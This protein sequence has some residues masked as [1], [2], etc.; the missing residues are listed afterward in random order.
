LESSVAEGR[1]SGV[2]QGDFSIDFIG[3]GTRRA[4]TTWLYHCLREHPEICMS[5]VKETFVFHD[6]L[7][8]GKGRDSSA[9]EKYF[10]HC[11][12]GTIK[13]EFTPHYLFDPATP[14]LIR[15]S[16]PDA[17]LV[18][19]FRNPVDRLESLYYFWKFRGRHDFETFEEFLEKEEFDA[20]N[21]TRYFSHL[22]RWLELFPRENILVLVY[23]D[24]ARDPA[25]F[26]R[27]VYS[28]LG[29]DPAFVPESVGKSINM[30]KDSKGQ[31]LSRLSYKVIRN[32]ERHEL[33]KKAVTRLLESRARGWFDTLMESGSSQQTPARAESA[34]PALSA[35]TRAR[36]MEMYRDEVAGLE[37]LLDRDLGEWR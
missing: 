1:E 12:S 32:I 28:F 7:G 16:F 36:V 30:G 34:R 21:E 17:R 6:F 8:L 4:G 20:R 11:P 18:V 24:I 3:I 15:Q 22:Q 33:G 10:G 13:G 26:V 31:V 25:A 23:E 14:G 9:Y 29:V 35:E 2:E 19:S 5:N 37:R 27:G